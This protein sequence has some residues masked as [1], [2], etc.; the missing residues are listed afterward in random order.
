MAGMKDMLMWLKIQQSKPEYAAAK[1]WMNRNQ[2]PL[3]DAS[4]KQAQKEVE[5]VDE[6][7]KDK[8]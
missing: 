3:P 4:N 5:V 2:T 7:P 1:R 6:T 8:D